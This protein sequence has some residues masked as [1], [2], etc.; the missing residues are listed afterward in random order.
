MLAWWKAQQWKSK[1]AAGGVHHLQ[2]G[3]S[4][5]KVI[6]SRLQ[7]TIGL[8]PSWHKAGEKNNN[9]AAARRA[10]ADA[11]KKAPP[12]AASQKSLKR[13]NTVQ[14]IAKGGASLQRRARVLR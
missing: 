10:K 8:V 3:E 14:K 6:I 5:G 13:M 1:R 12:P 4:Q 9:G 2:P 11:P 7:F